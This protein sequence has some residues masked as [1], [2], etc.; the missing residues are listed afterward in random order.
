MN[1]EQ[2]V[3]F[4]TVVGEILQEVGAKESYRI[5]L[6]GGGYMVTQ[7]GNRE[8][9][10][11]IDCIFTSATLT[12][13]EHTLFAR[14]VAIALEEL[15]QEFPCE[16]TDSFGDHLQ[17]VTK[18]PAG[19]LW[20]KTGM[21]EVFVPDDRY[22][23]ALKLEAGREKDL[24]DIRALFPRV[25]ISTRKEAQHLIAEVYH[26][27]VRRGR[28]KQLRTSLDTVFRALMQEGNS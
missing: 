7:V 13:P 2:I 23:L 20:L 28:S 12:S 4:F 16:F 24:D 5:L 9:T 21:L 6:I 14:V 19:R 8:A 18:L 26:P 17:S 3:R 27:W 10:K 22:I 15:S 25:G 1:A 11:D